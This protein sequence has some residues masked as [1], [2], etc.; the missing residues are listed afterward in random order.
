MCIRDRYQRRVRGI[1]PENTMA[2][3]WFSFTLLA[4]V[5]ATQPHIFLVLID[6]LGWANVGNRAGTG[7]G[8]TVPEEAVT[9]NMDKLVRHG[10]R[11][12][13]HYT[14]NYCSPSRASLQSGRLP[15]HVSFNNDD[16]TT[17]NPSDPVSGFA[18][19]PREM[20]GIAEKLKSGG[21]STHMTGKWDAG[22]ATWEQ[23]PIGRGYDSFFGYY[24]HA[25]D[26]YTQTLGF[27]STGSSDICEAHN[28]SLVDLWRDH[29]P[30]HGENGTLYEEELFARNTLRVIEDHDLSSG[31]PLFMF[32]SFHLIHTPLEVPAEFEQEFSFLTDR[33]RRLYAAMVKYM[34]EKLGMFV[35]A[36]HQKGM[37]DNTLMVVSSD[38]GG[39]IYETGPIAGGANNIPLKGGKLSDW[40]GGVRVN[41][42][43]SGG[44]LPSSVRGTE[45]DSYIH[46]ADW[47]GT[48]CHLAG[49][50]A[51]D[52]RAQA[53]G[54]PG[55]DS[56][57][58]WPL[59]IGQ[60]KTAARTDIYLS[61]VSVRV[62]VI[63]PFCWAS[64]CS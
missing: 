44:V 60:T 8:S 33:N 36:L 48:L 34:D 46:I 18:G 62:N 2:V 51:T 12:N 24:H 47:Y 49:V 50:N 9:P 56:I 31:Q 53:A 54:L 23:T 42:F 28:M 19:I 4:A 11:L 35:E 43:V 29:G 5:S 17:W 64:T 58:H 30:A 13:R 39:P 10:I 14:Y 26:Y 55:V 38:N 25:N 32:H 57:N 52:E 15:M 37:W 16:P 63:F 21:Y 40:E 45:L 59:L 22:M 3:L 27:Q 20:T 41:A 7:N 61:K 1:W 6:D